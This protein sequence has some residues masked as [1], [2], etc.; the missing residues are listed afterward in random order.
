MISEFRSQ[1][2]TN[3]NNYEESQFEDESMVDSSAAGS[4]MQKQKYNLFDSSDSDKESES[5]AVEKRKKNKKKV[6]FDSSD[7]DGPGDR[8]LVTHSEADSSIGVS[9]DDAF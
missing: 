3:K 8:K 5:V 1:T 2:R 6:M 7:S 4:A 9:E